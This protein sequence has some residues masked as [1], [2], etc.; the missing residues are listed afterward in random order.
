[1]NRD[2][3]LSADDLKRETVSVPEWGGTVCVRTMTGAERDQ[4]EAEML[5]TR[6]TSAENKLAN[7]R[8]RLCVLTICDDNGARLFNDGDVVALGAKSAAALDRCFTVAQ[9]LSKYSAGDVDD[10]AK[11]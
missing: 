9:R 10:L 5:R 2:A 4:F 3:I 7:I 8:A 1:L 11:N 6:G